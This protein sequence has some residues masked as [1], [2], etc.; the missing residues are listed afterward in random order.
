[1]AMTMSGEYE[2]PVPRETVWEKLND[3][4]TLKAC[5]PG[6]EQL[7]QALRH[8]TPG[9]GHDQDRAGE[10]EVQRQGHAVRS[11][12]AERLQD[13]R[14]GRRRGCG[15]CQGRRDGEAHAE[16]RR[17]AAGV[18]GRGPDRRQAGAARP[19]PDQRRR[20]EN[21]RRILRRTS[22]PPSASE[23]PSGDLLA[24]CPVRALPLVA[25][26]AASISICGTCA[27]WR[28]SSRWSKASVLS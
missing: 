7:G 6:A 3:A 18:H 4:E 26:I 12:S 20:Q 15:L 17:H 5:I 28:M 10:G 22:P 19:A 16:E 14:A 11:R 9:G 25:R 8:G 21:S 24:P 23:V 13:F 2:L 1:M 27:A